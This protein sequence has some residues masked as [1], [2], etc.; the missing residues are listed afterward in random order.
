MA[1]LYGARFPAKVRKL[2]LA[3]TS[4]DTSAGPSALSMLADQIPTVV[5]QELVR[6]GGGLMPGRKV[7]KFWGPETVS[8]EDIRQLLQT[9]ERSALTT[10][11]SW[12]HYFAAG[13]PGP[14][15]CQARLFLKS[16]INF[17]DA[18]NWRRAI[19]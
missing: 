16:S 7:L 4:V 5:F 14:S 8:A 13:M 2:V 9:E 17:T 11:A 19:S 3:G 15:T 6:L 1:L 10:S 12:K 18:M